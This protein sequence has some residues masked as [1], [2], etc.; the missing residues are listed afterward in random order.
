MKDQGEVK[1]GAGLGR[2]AHRTSYLEEAEARAERRVT[3]CAIEKT[4]A[5]NP[6]AGPALHGGPLFGGGEL[7]EE[8]VG[9]GL[10]GFGGESF[11]DGSVFGRRAGVSMLKKMVEVCELADVGVFIAGIGQSLLDERHIDLGGNLQ[12]FLAV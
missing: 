3:D 6:A 5:A 8:P 9:D 2:R 7:R 1:L 10:E 4:G 12:I 11:F